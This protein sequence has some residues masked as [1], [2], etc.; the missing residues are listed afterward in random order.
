M[1]G[2][3]YLPAVTFDFCFV[4]LQIVLMRAAS[5]CTRCVPTVHNV[6]EKRKN[7]CKK[8]KKNSSPQCSVERVGGRKVIIYTVCTRIRFV[9]RTTRTCIIVRT[10][11]LLLLRY[12]CRRRGRPVRERIRNA[13]VSFASPPVD[14]VRAQGRRRENERRGARIP[15][16]A[17]N[18]N[19]RDRCN[20]RLAT[21]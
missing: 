14:P 2:T 5:K 7:E 8:K 17:Q 6:T 12:D 21:P 4:F 1:D 19:N 11:I 15:G 10:I 9:P 3:R 18:Q 13:E 20:P 16:K